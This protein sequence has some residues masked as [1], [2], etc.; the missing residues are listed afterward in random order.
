MS[1]F[2]QIQE[3]GKY[4]LLIIGLILGFLMLVVPLNELLPPILQDF[5]PVY[6]ENKSLLVYLTEHLSF[7]YKIVPI[8]FFLIIIFVIWR[9]K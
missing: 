1:L 3:A 6:L 8:A 9:K 7:F 5:I 4:F 2:K